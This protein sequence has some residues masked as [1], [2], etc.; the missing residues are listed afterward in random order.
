MISWSPGKAAKPPKKLRKKGP[1]LASAGH[2]PC[3]GEREASPRPD[4]TTEHLF[5]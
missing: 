5:V 4:L 3:R 1:P 2:A